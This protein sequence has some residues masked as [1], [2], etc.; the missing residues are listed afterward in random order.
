MQ[1]QTG[2]LLGSQLQVLSETFQEPE[3]LSVCPSSLPGPWGLLTVPY[4][5]TGS[6]WFSLQMHSAHTLVPTCTLLSQVPLD[7][8]TWNLARM[9]P[10]AVPMVPP[11]CC[12]YTPHA[13]QMWRRYRYLFSAAGTTYTSYGP[14][15]CSTCWHWAPHSPHS[16]WSLPVVEPE[17]STDSSSWYCRPE[18]PTCQVSSSWHQIHLHSLPQ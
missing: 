2:H 16:H 14:W 3:H 8:P 4:Q 10:H 17:T 15:S 13:Y 12:T 11:T 9:I 1:A 18:A 5:P 7:V 6:A